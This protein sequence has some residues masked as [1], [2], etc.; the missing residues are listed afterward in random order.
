MVAEVSD[1]DRI[2]FSD[3]NVHRLG[4]KYQV[5]QVAVDK[6]IMVLENG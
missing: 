4:Q 6:A 5:V 2:G 3:I 1:V